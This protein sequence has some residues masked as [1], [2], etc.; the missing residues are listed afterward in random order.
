M[1]A[2]DC[3]PKGGELAVSNDGEHTFIHAT[4]MDA[5]A[6][7]GV[8]ACLSLQMPQEDL[9]PALMH[10]YVT[11]LLAG[12]YGYTIETDQPEDGLVRFTIS[13]PDF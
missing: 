12:H 7:E 9:T 10:A 11:G 5:R 13:L 4:G 3:L 1:L 2:K 6:K 8:Q